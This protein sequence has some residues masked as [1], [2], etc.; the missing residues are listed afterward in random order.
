MGVEWFIV[1]RPEKE[2]SLL[3]T[4]SI[5]LTSEEKDKFRNTHE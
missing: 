5:K 2:L 1:T 4:G 3:E